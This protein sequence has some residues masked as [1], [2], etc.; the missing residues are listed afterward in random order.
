MAVDKVAPAGALFDACPAGAAAFDG[1]EQKVGFLPEP[2]ERSGG[3]LVE[4]GGEA[5]VAARVVAS[6]Q[7]LYFAAYGARQGYAAGVA[8]NGFGHVGGEVGPP[9]G[10]QLAVFVLPLVSV[11]LG[12]GMFEVG[13]EV[14]RFVEEYPQEEIG[15]EV[16]VDGDFM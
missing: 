4:G 2:E 16:A 3:Q 14:S 1:T 12:M 11:G 10:Q 5:A 6:Q 15:V 8:R 7:G 9:L 13:V